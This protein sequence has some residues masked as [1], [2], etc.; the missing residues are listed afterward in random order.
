MLNW[1]QRNSK[2]KRE[3]SRKTER[4]VKMIYGEIKAQCILS[5]KYQKQ[6]IIS[7]EVL[8][9][10]LVYAHRSS[11]RPYKSNQFISVALAA[12]KST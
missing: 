6:C 2:G 11:S 7:S 5:P 4:I 12:D 1:L 8:I 10:I 9:E 3:C